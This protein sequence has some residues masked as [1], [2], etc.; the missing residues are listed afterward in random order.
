ME[1]LGTEI[2][3]GVSAKGRLQTTTLPVGAVGNDRPLVTTNETWTST[4]LHITVLSKTSDPRNGDTTMRLINISR[5][6]PDPTLFQAPPDYQ[7]EEEPG[8]SI[9][10]RSPSSP[11][12]PPA[13]AR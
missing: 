13:P 12:P 8:N 10:I 3:E 9:S 11:P 4:E 2:I 1:D 5:A 6:E 7:I